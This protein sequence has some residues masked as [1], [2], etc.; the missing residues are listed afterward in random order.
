[1]RKFI[2]AA[3]LAGVSS[4][5]SS[6]STTGGGPFG[7]VMFEKNQ[8]VS[9]AGSLFAAD[10]QPCLTASFLLSALSTANPDAGEPV[11]CQRLRSRLQHALGWRDMFA[12]VPAH[13]AN[14][15]R[16]R[17]NEALSSLIAAS[18]DKCGQYVQFLQ[19]YQGNVR[20]STGI[21][22]QATAILA[23]ISSG[24][25]AQ[26]FAATS[27]IASGVGTSLQQAHFQNQT[28]AMLTKAFDSRR[29]EMLRNMDGL[30]QCSVDQY[31]FARGFADVQNYHRA[32]SIVVGL[33]E[34]QEAVEEKNSP[35]LETFTKLLEKLP[36]LQATMKKISKAEDPKPDPQP[37]SVVEPAPE[38]PMVQD[39]AGNPQ[40]PIE[41]AENNLPVTA[42][43]APA[44]P[45][46]AKGPTTETTT[47]LSAG[48]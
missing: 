3:M 33:E 37:Q 1:M 22:S 29:S 36:A 35:S 27:G 34:A 20:S 9:G 40:L 48:K 47:G 24:G 26:G 32:C 2:F 39:D 4:I 10:E 45:F 17:R 8:H 15:E 38:Q 25:T 19:Q 5:L 14:D 21:L 11:V 44:C 30:M 13:L 46:T 43:P 7:I 16:R 28:V 31:P 42:N 12:P 41:Q 18:N 6:C 23:T